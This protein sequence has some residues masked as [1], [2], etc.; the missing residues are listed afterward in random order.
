VAKV[1]IKILSNSPQN[2]GFKEYTAPFPYLGA[3][4][5]L[6]TLSNNSTNNNIK[7]WFFYGVNRC[8][9]T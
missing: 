7:P 1:T 9:S 8:K 3:I 5:K 4:Q 2:L 6:S